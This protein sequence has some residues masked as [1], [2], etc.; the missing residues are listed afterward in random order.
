M[1]AAP[2][3]QILPPLS[4]AQ[5]QEWRDDLFDEDGVRAL[6][7][8]APWEVLVTEFSPLTFGKDEW[9]VHRAHLYSTYE[10]EYHRA[11]WDSTH[12]FPASIAKRRASRYLAPS[13]PVVTSG[14]SRQGPGIE[15]A[16]EPVEKMKLVKTYPDRPTASPTD[17][18]TARVDFDERLLPEDSWERDLVK[19]ECEVDLIADVR[20]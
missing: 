19:G 8:S 17:D 13:T 4:N 6:I 5:S 2:A 12:A 11:Y 1:A 14:D 7:E 16:I 18:K 10:A 15:D 20:A 3:A 9:L